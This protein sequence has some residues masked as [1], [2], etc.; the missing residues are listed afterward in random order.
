[1]QGWKFPDYWSSVLSNPHHW[2]NTDLYEI[3]ENWLS[4]VVPSSSPCTGVGRGV[5]LWILVAVTS[6]VVVAGIVGMLKSF[7][8]CSSA[9][10]VKWE[11]REQLPNFPKPE[12]LCQI[13]LFSICKM[14]VETKG[15]FVRLV[16][17]CGKDYFR[18]ILA[19]A[20]KK[21][22][23]YIENIGKERK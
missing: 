16:F 4:S 22:L 13:F 12:T 10:T 1:M 3:E 6:D 11:P 21:N 19:N 15:C 20:F 7:S 23:V 14:L 5:L 8:G 18:P 17:P 2:Q 9:L